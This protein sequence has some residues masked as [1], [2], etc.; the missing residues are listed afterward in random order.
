MRIRYLL[1]AAGLIAAAGPVKAQSAKEVG[2]NVHR[3]LKKAGNDTKAELKRA[4]SGAHRALKANGNE[5]KEDAGEVTG[6]VKAPAPLDSAA[7]KISHASKKAGRHA[8]HSLKKNAS[9]AHHE[10]KKA[11]NDTKAA[12]DTTIRKP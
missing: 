9:K 12:V 11:G 10:L 3:T 2:A 1:V 5:A 6:D 4:S 8:K 7:H